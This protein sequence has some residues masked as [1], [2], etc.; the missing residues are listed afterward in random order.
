MCIICIE[1]Q[2]GK[3]SLSEAFNN[4][5]ESEEILS[6]EHYDEVNDMLNEAAELESLKEYYLNNESEYHVDDFSDFMDAG[7]SVWGADD[8]YDDEYDD[9]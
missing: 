7:T 3:L 1:W 6:E 9:N 5:I 8:E 4:L 2:K